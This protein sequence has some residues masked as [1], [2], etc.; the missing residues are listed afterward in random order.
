MYLYLRK[1]IILPEET[2][3]VVV[4][5]VTA[6]WLADLWD[7]FPYL[8]VTSPEPRS[9]KTR[10]LELLEHICLRAKL[11]VST[12]GPSLYRKIAKDKLANKMPTLL[13]DEAQSLTRQGSE[14]SEVLRELLRGGISKTAVASRCVG[15]NHDPTDFPVYCP[16]VLS[17]IGKLDGITA[18]RC[19]PVLMKRKKKGEV[20]AK[21]RSK[22][23]AQEAKVLC[24]LLEKW[25]QDARTL[26]AIEAAYESLEPFDMANDRMAELLLPLQAVLSVAAKQWRKR[27]GLATSYLPYE[28]LKAYAW[29]LEELEEEIERQSPGIRLLAA[30]RDI[31]TDYSFLGTESLLVGLSNRAG[32]PWATWDKGKPLSAKGLS[33]LLREFDIRPTRNKDQ[34]CRG[35]DKADFE[36]AW[37][38]YL[39]DPPP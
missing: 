12:S 6:S 18:D 35:Y 15:Q 9:G 8:A 4:A 7:R 24:D 14:M 25:S 22:V 3:V 39:P 13:F 11:N 27:S 19:L 1:Y 33:T 16:K 38:R 28:M 10:V 21:Y 31:F 29:G 20:V 34:T 36:D 26:Q 30:C 37:A 5:W 32:E 2:L 17:L 23:A